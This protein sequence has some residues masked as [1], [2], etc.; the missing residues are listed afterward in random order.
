LSQ[1]VRIDAHRPVEQ[2]LVLVFAAMVAGFLPTSAGAQGIIVY[3]VILEQPAPGLPL[4]AGVDDGAGFSFATLTDDDGDG[5]IELPPGPVPGGLA[6]GVT[7]AAGQIPGCDIWDFSSNGVS[8]AS[9]PLFINALANE[10]VGVDYG[11][12]MS[13]PFELTPGQRFTIANG[14]FPGWPGIRLVDESGVSGLEEFVRDV[15]TLPN[16]NGEVIVSNTTVHFTLVPELSSV[17]LA[18]IGLIAA[19]CIRHGRRRCG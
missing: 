16:F 18:T 3:K 9:V 1:A 11:V 8:G 14:V 4:M 17:A 7:P 19:G 13:P 6:L 15:D 2:L 10:S 12:V 5:L